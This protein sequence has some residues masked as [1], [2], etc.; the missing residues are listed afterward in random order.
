MPNLALAGG[1]YDLHACVRAKK[2]QKL[3]LSMVP[4]TDSIVAPLPRPDEK[5]NHLYVCTYEL[6][7]MGDTIYN[8]AGTVRIVG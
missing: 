5:E 1:P 2:P 8:Y 3:Y 7:I 4:Y 6:N